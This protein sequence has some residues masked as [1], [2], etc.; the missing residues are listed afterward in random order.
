MVGKNGHSTTA[1][2]GTRKLTSFSLVFFL[3]TTNTGRELCGAPN[4]QALPYRLPKILYWGSTYLEGDLQIHSRVPS[5]RNHSRAYGCGS[6]AFQAASDDTCDVLGDNLL[7]HR[8]SRARPSGLSSQSHQVR[9]FRRSEHAS[10]NA[11]S[12]EQIG[13]ST[14]TEKVRK[15]YRACL[16][17]RLEDWG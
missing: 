4:K 8:H 10:R 3:S 17:S 5:K 13:K 12:T 6:L 9:P 15:P 7:A 11:R 2:V 1:V 14:K 16:L